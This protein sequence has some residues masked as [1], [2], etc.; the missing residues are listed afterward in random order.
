MVDESLDA[1][2]L[3]DLGVA[4]Q[5][6]PHGAACRNRE[7]ERIAQVRFTR[8]SLLEKTDDRRLS[9]LIH[10]VDQ[11]VLENINL[12]D[13][14]DDFALVVLGDKANKV[15][16]LLAHG[17][18]GTGDKKNQVRRGDMLLRDPGV[19]GPQRGVDAGTI[20]QVDELQKG[21]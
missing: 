13:D 17:S 15:D 10:E 7:D 20:D 6:G 12:I 21:E 3:P 18:L 19:F 5:D 4:I 1:A 8:Q 14:E 16:F 9:F 11:T 2:A